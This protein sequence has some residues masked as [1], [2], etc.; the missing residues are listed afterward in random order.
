MQLM[1]QIDNRFINLHMLYLAGSQ[2]NT[3]MKG[4]IEKGKKKVQ[5]N[6]AWF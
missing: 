1:I 2:L 6:L 3:L 5:F 4:Y